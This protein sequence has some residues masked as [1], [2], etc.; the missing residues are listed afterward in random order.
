MIPARAELKPESSP[1]GGF[2]GRQGW[3]PSS[4]SPSGNVNSYAGRVSEA[5]HGGLNS[6]NLDSNVGQGVAGAYP[7]AWAAR[8]EAAGV[9][10]DQVQSAWSAPNA[11]SKLA[12]ASALEKVSSGRWQSKHSNHYQAD[13]EVMR[14]S[15]TES[16]SH[17]KSYTNSTY[18]RL[19]VTGGREYYDATLSR[20]AERGLTIDGSAQVVRKELPDYE[21]AK[22]PT[23]SELKERD[24]TN[25]SDRRQPDHADGK[26]GGPESQSST[27]S[28][29]SARPKLKLLP[30][31]RPVESLEPPVVDHAQ[32]FILLPYAPLFTFFL[33]Y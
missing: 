17:T 12:H 15:E 29:P 3:T 24:L 8:K 9:A 19:E 7:N 32:V 30:R 13:F 4:Q 6:L 28:E 31:T 25:F 1:T 33:S 2:Q 11:V 20:H 27:L 26:F 14:S 18:N 22:A 10:A 23:N 16:G 21:R 5:N